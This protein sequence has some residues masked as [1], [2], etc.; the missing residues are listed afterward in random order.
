ME[1]R[2]AGDP[3]DSGDRES[4]ANKGVLKKYARKREVSLEKGQHSR[5]EF[6]RRSSK[7][8]QNG[9]RGGAKQGARNIYR[10]TGG[11]IMRTDDRNGYGG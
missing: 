8:V 5:D 1:G 4:A 10:I 2:A 9:E 11:Q 3:P 7:Y 6:R